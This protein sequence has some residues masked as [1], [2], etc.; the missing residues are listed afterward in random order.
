[1]RISKKNFFSLG[2][3]LLAVLLLAPAC[4]K[5][6]PP[7]PPVKDGNILAVPENVTY[8]LEG[9]Q[10][11]L[12]WNHTID[13]VTAKLAPEA[14]EVYMAT[15][16]LQDCEGCP[17]VFVSQGLVPMPEMVYRRTLDPGI[18]YYFRVQAIG[19]DEIKS[20]I[21]KTRYITIEK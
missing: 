13:P 17:F 2:F 5:K 20:G 10:L 18:H 14:F 3:I 7:I 6:G 15:K 4:G 19:K 16:N 11:T 8:S 1:M 21:S 12:T 9:D